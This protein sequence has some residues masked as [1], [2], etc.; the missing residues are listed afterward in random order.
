MAVAQ[1]TLCIG[2]ARVAEATRSKLWF[3]CILIIYL[4][5]Y[6]AATPGTYRISLYRV[7]VKQLAAPMLS[8][9]GVECA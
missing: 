4:T 1:D 6:L 2:I 9:R 5:A 8:K 3:L 7:G